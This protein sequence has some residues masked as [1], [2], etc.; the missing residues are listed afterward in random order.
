MAETAKKKHEKLPL[1]D[2]VNELI[3]KERTLLNL[4]LLEKKSEAEEWKSKYDSLFDTLNSK[5]LDGDSVTPL[6]KAAEIESNGTHAYAS[7]HEVHKLV[8]ERIHP[9]ILD[10]SHVTMERLMFA[11]LCKAVFGSRSGIGGMGGMGL[12]IE[13]LNTAVLSGCSLNDD[14]CPALM[15]LFRASRLQA[16]DLSHNSLSEVFFLQLLG[17]LKDRRATPQYILLDGNEPFSHTVKTLSSLLDVLTEQT[18]GLTFSMQDFAEFSAHSAHKHHGKTP[19]REH[20][21]DYK[22]T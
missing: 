22:E 18:W 16:V 11:K 5:V 12:S 3:E 4:K 20:N 15:A 9:W 14:H 19:K 8:Y 17:A 21:A 13:E 6:E 2:E 1:M 7:S 10:L